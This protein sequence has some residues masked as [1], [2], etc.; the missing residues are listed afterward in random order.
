MPMT[1]CLAQFQGTVNPKIPLITPGPF[2]W[3]N[4]TPTHGSGTLHQLL[5][6]A[7]G[8]A[9]TCAS[10]FHSDALASNTHSS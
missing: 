3:D 9:L 10:P 4:V 8:T 5:S 7:H 2:F 6:F 1:C